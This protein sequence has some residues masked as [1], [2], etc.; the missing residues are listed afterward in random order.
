[1]FLPVKF[2]DSIGAIFMVAGLYDANVAPK[3]GDKVPVYR[4]CTVPP[5]EFLGIVHDRAPMVLLPEQY[6]AWLD[7]GADALKLVGVYPD[8]G[9]F[10]VQPA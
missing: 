1:M 5:N 9:A 3:T 7:G 10:V 2:L 4:M 8:A 6:G